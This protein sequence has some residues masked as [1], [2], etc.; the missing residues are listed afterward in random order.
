MAAADGRLWCF[1]TVLLRNKHPYERRIAMDPAGVDSAGELF[2]DG[3]SETPRRVDGTP[4]E[5]LVNLSTNCAVKASSQAPGRDP[6]YAVDNY[7]R[8]WWQPAKT[9]AAPWLE[10][11]LGGSF[12]LRFARIVFGDEGLDYKAGAVPAPYL[13]RILGSA[14]GSNWKLLCES[15]KSE[16]ERHIVLQKLEACEPCRYV[17]LESLEAPLGMELAVI[18]FS[19]FGPPEL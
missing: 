12:P 4:E 14:D 16:E 6:A 17:R 5:P 8:T 18:D 15:S 11:D 1:Y 13:H 3:P 9:D 7:V 2:I 10:L 19:V